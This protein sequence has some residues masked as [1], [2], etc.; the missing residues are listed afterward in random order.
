MRR[1]N[2]MVEFTLIAM[3]LIFLMLGTFEAARWAWLYHTLASA[4]KAGARFA[5]V[6][7]NNCATSP[8]QCTITQAQVAQAIQSAGLGLAPGDLTVQ[9]SVA[10]NSTRNVGPMPLSQLLTGTACWPV[11]DNCTRALPGATTADDVQVSL[12]YPFHSAVMRVN[13]PAAARERVRF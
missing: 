4:A 13:L 8:N 12:T 2:A 11:S 9:L 6:H 7:G 5:S 1:G 3:P 10:G